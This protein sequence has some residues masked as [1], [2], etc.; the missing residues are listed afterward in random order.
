MNRT[1]RT[2]SRVADTPF[3]AEIAA[4]AA[5]GLQPV[6]A[7]DIRRT[8]R[9]LA[10]PGGTAA[11]AAFDEGSVSAGE[12][13]QEI[14]E[15]EFELKQGAP[16]ALYRLALDLHRVAPFT[17]GTESKAERG[18][19]LVT[20]RGPQSVESDPPP[21]DARGPAVEAARRIIAAGL[22]HVLA[23]QTA[24]ASRDVEGVHQVR[25][26]IRRL[27]TALALFGQL[28]RAACAHSSARS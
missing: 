17:I 1:R 25:V 14:S 24:A 21:L 12:Q 3:A 20:G 28:P 7:T 5:A 11:E 9:N 16:G 18:Q 19:R 22:F 15:L 6:F 10:L 26:G 13:A 23:N 8:V 27:R 4:E 2:S